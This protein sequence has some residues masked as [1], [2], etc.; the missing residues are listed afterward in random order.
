[1]QVEEAMNVK[2][3]TSEREGRRTAVLS[4]VV[5]GGWTLLEAAERMEVS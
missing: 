4:R 3:G 5:K 2:K 1:M